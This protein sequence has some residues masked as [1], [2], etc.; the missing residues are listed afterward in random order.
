MEVVIFHFQK[1]EVMM[2]VSTPRAFFFYLL[3]AILTI[4]PI[5]GYSDVQVSSQLQYFRNVNQEFVIIKTGTNQVSVCSSG[6]ICD[7][8]DTT[9]YSIQKLLNSSIPTANSEYELAYI[10]NYV[11]NVSLTITKFDVLTGLFTNVSLNSIAPLLYTKL[12]MSSM[13]HAYLNVL[14]DN[15]YVI[16]FSKLSGIN[17][18][19]T[20]VIFK[21]NLTL[22]TFY[23]YPRD[24]NMGGNTALIGKGSDNYQHNYI[25]PPCYNDDGKVYYM[26]SDRVTQYNQHFDKEGIDEMDYDGY[27]I[28][29]IGNTITKVIAFPMWK[30]EVKD[31]VL[32]STLGFYYDYPTNGYNMAVHGIY[33]Y[34]SGVGIFN[35]MYVYQNKSGDTQNISYVAT[36]LS[37]FD[38]RLTV[39]TNG[40]IVYTIND[41][42]PVNFN[43][44][45]QFH[46]ASEADGSYGGM[47]FVG[48]NIVW[49]NYSNGKVYFINGAPSTSTPPTVNFYIKPYNN[50]YN[51]LMKGYN[52]FDLVKHTTTNFY[53]P[54][55]YDNDTTNAVYRTMYSADTTAEPTTYFLIQSDDPTNDPLNIEYNCDNEE[56]GTPIDGDNYSNHATSYMR[57]NTSC[58]YIIY[59]DY[60]VFDNCND[61]VK[62]ST[63]ASSPSTNSY[64]SLFTIGAGMGYEV[65]FYNKYDSEEFSIE[66]RNVFNNVTSHYTYLKVNDQTIWNDTEY[67]QYIDNTVN[68]RVTFTPVSTT[69]EIGNDEPMGYTIDTYTTSNILPIRYIEWKFYNKT[70][71]TIGYN[72]TWIGE[73]SITN[74][75]YHPTQ[76]DVTDYGLHESWETVGGFNITYGYNRYY[77]ISCNYETGDEK[78]LRIYYDDNDID[79]T[80]YKDFLIK[81]DAALNAYV[82]D[83]ELL[84]ES[85]NEALDEETI[86]S[87]QA[88]VC[89]LFN[90]CSANQRF[91]F[92]MIFI[93][94]TVVLT[95]IVMHVNFYPTG[96]SY[97]VPLSL[98][99]MEFL[100]F[101]V[102]KFFPTWF[103]FANIFI[104]AIAAGSILNPMSWFGGNNNRGN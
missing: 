71:T 46:S 25:T 32:Y 101:A 79:Y 2:M 41:I 55:T 27:K 3:I 23:G 76:S 95:V 40:D 73:W 75:E 54:Y 47:G 86:I 17:A 26:L 96:A 60:L 37:D 85:V 81:Y 45:L 22:S 90:I 80:I 14:G 53:Y 11:P 77:G 18:E 87:T 30:S 94:I 12:Y 100:F 91:M 19:T 16:S 13:T 84:G 83:K 65:R 104:I 56:T 59:N 72:F 51:S 24:T 89:K 103:V 15:Y 5:L 6:G 82:L 33:N 66:W 1:H 20:V 92:A 57:Y 42:E 62:F 67:N 31:C 43:Y 99:S 48:D 44:D 97:L 93:I 61:T 38:S 21:N 78:F 58:D 34:T 68:L 29:T 69:Y 102:N 4:T 10:S 39:K 28:L 49:Y 64:T 8:H 74:D 98:Y 9:G 52:K 7:T 88:T 36:S 63:T 35:D 50:K 70:N